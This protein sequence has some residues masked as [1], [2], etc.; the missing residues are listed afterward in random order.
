VPTFAVEI[1]QVYVVIFP[2][3]VGPVFEAQAVTFPVPEIVQLNVPVGAAALFAPVRVAVKVIVPPRVAEPEGE[4]TRVGVATET[5][6]EVEEA[7][8]DTAL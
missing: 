1:V 4:I 6:V 8:P 3:V 2:A 5:T 7:T